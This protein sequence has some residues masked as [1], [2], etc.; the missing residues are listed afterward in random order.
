MISCDPKTG[1]PK[2][3]SKGISIF[4]CPDANQTSPNKIF[5]MILVSS[6]V[7]IDIS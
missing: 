3:P 4:D 1:S 6:L 2:K 7:D 5:F